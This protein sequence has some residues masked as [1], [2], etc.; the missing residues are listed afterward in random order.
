MT[1]R[2]IVRKLVNGKRS[3][4]TRTNN[5]RIGEISY[6]RSS[7][8]IYA[9]RT[10]GAMRHFPTRLEACAWLMDYYDAQENIGGKQAC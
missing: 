9:T 10:D 5:I 8:Q 2:W 4:W 6:G 1:Q 3:V 7:R